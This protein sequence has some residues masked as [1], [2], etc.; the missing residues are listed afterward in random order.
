MF[1]RD[2]ETR[3]SYQ[4]MKLEDYLKKLEQEVQQCREQYEDWYIENP[5]KGN[6]AYWAALILP[7]ALFLFLGNKAMKFYNRKMRKPDMVVDVD[8]EGNNIVGEVSDKLSSIQE[9]ILALGTALSASYGVGLSNKYTSFD[10]YLDCISID[11]TNYN[12]YRK[13]FKNPNYSNYQKDIW[14]F[15][16]LVECPDG[17]N[18]ICT[19]NSQKCCY[20]SDCK[21]Y[22]PKLAKGF[23]PSLLK[24]EYNCKPNCCAP[25]CCYDDYFIDVCIGNI[26]D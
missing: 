10:K 18:S 19:V 15:G 11:N 2:F 4:G 3:L 22:D 12:I 21:Y 8:S 24:K 25:G 26:K 13:I 6:L 9:I 20:N 17:D 23:D 16:A 14:K 7:P 1:V 5:W